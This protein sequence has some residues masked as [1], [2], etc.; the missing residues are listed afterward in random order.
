V[1]AHR[2][3]TEKALSKRNHLLI[4]TQNAKARELHDL[5]LGTN[6]VVQGEN[7][8]W[9][10]TGKIVEVLPFRQYRI[11]MFHSGRVI[12]RNRQFLRE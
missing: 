9:E 12:L 3:G 10:R 5:P 11:R 4:K 6:V 8:K 2:G 7:K 1:G